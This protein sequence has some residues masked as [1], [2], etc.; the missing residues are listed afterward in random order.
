MAD[1][2]LLDLDEEIGVVY[3]RMREELGKLKANV[4]PTPF[5]EATDKLIAGMRS[6]D[7][8]QVHA[9]VNRLAELRTETLDHERTWG[10]ILRLIE[11]RRRLVESQ[12]KRILELNLTMTRA[13][14]VRIANALVESVTR[15]VHDAD[16]LRAIIDEINAV[17][18]QVSGDTVH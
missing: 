14:G 4:D 12:R 18:G 15:H 8:D 17:R 9:A 5:A 13:E 10:Q 1:P 2:R 6:G 16:T 3:A 7:S 11:R